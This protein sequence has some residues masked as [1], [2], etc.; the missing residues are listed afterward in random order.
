MPEEV[1]RDFG[2]YWIRMKEKSGAEVTVAEYTSHGWYVCGQDY[3]FP[4]EWFDVV[5]SRLV[6]P[7]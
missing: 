6:E 5:S 3:A 7:T 2:Y 4:E 1:T